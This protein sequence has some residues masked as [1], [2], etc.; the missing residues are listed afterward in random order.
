MPRLLNPEAAERLRHSS[1][2]GRALW[3]EHLILAEAERWMAEK[4]YAHAERSLKKLLTR[5]YE[6]TAVRS[7]AEAL[8]ESLK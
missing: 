2:A 4:K 8:L 3:L 7:R 6:G 5:R 1:P